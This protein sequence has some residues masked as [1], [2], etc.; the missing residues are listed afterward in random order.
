MVELNS[1]GHILAQNPQ[2]IVFFSAF[3]DLFQMFTLLLGEMI[4]FDDHIVQRG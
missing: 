3:W 2:Q 4:Q 1:N